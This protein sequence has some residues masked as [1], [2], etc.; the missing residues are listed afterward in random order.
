MTDFT[1]N[2]NFEKPDVGASTGTWGGTLND[3]LDA[4][5]TE[6]KDAKDDAAA[7]QATANAALPKAGGTMTGRLTLVGFGFDQSALSTGGAI[8]LDLTTKN[9][10]N[11]SVT[12]NIS[13]TFINKPGAWWIAHIWLNNPAA[14]TMTFNDT[15]NWDR[16]PTGTAQAPTSSGD[17]GGG[18]GYVYHVT[19]YSDGSSFFGTWERY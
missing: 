14:Y 9:F 17:V 11:I 1:T 19:I 16:R 12:A 18:P 10:F 2:Y 15:I 13:F 4:I 7:A 6:I 8:S 3:D 5:D